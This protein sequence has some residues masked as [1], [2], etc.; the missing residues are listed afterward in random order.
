MAQSSWE[1]SRVGDVFKAREHTSSEPQGGYWELKDTVVNITAAPAR[2]RCQT[3][4]GK[5]RIFVTRKRWLWNLG[6]VLRISAMANASLNCQV[7]SFCND[8]SIP[9][10]FL[11]LPILMILPFFPFFCSTFSLN[12]SFP[13]HLLIFF[14]SFLYSISS[15][16]PLLDYHG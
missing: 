16:P 1:I 10:H 9:P 3:L 2:F 6:G 7:R 11:F 8:S 4:S 14:H 12:L 5:R 15:S 13:S